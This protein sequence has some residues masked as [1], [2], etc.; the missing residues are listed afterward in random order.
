MDVNKG[1]GPPDSPG[2][3]L[4]LHFGVFLHHLVELLRIQGEHVAVGQRSG[5]ED[6]GEQLLVVA[7]VL[8]C[9]PAYLHNGGAQPLVNVPLG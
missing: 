8:C 6:G 5:C 4:D 9:V 1:E 2:M 7:Y 3:Q